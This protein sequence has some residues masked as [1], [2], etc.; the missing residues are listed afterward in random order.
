MSLNNLRIMIDI[1]SPVHAG[2]DVAKATLQLH[3]QSRL[4]DLSNDP[5]GHTQLV[6]LLSTVPGVHLITEATGGYERKAVHALHAA[7]LPVSVIN[8]M[9]TRAFARASGQRAK[10]DPLD[11]ASLSAY[12][13]A[14][15]PA[16]SPAPAAAQI[17]LA[18]LVSWREQLKALLTIAKNQAE[19]HEE[20]F[21]CA[22]HAKL[23]R[24]LED[25]LTA[26]ALALTAML[27][28]HREKQKQV[29]R[30]VEISGV[31]VLTAVTVLAQ[32]PELGTL[33]RGQA[34]ALAGLAPWTRQSGPWEG[35]RHIGGGRA[36]VRRALYMS[37]VASVRCNRPLKAFYRRLRDAGKPPKVALTA[38]MRKLIVLMNHALKDPTFSLAR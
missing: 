26:V 15:R 16:P 38:V 11:A 30:L 5:V 31:G 27:A 23:V 25:R 10:N 24:H 20:T 2:L 1:P 29:N 7:G 35:Q 36:G 17:E 12:G 13:A 19:H 4:Y 8:P 6:K 3:L 21:V 22:E 14:L 9:Q 33:N 32:M 28:R 37:A 18:A 34:A